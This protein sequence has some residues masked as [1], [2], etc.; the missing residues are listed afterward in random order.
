MLDIQKSERIDSDY[1]K[2]IEY[3]CVCVFTAQLVCVCVWES[4]EKELNEF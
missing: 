1:S 4:E 3:D 2:Q